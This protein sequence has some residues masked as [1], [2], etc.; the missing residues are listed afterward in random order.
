MFVTGDAKV[1]ENGVLTP[2]TSVFF[3]LKN[4]QPSTMFLSE[5]VTDK[6]GGGECLQG[7]LWYSPPASLTS[8]LASV[9]FKMAS[10]V[11]FELTDKISILSRK[12]YSDFLDLEISRSLLS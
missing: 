7:N 9:T 11:F 4:R 6:P 10:K 12:Y 2:F 5:I 1:L 8:R 3:S